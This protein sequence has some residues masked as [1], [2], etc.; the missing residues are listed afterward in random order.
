MDSCNILQPSSPLNI[1]K[2]F[3]KHKVVNLETSLKKSEWILIT[4]QNTAELLTSKCE[5][6]QRKKYLDEDGW[7][8]DF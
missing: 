7:P 8:R 2:S 4:G 5:E 6:L 3:L 1:K